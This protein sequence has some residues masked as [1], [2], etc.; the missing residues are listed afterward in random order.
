VETYFSRR[1]DAE[2]VRQSIAHL[3][4]ENHVDSLLN[5]LEECVA[6]PK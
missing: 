2:E 3:T 6:M 4:L 1:P 5:V